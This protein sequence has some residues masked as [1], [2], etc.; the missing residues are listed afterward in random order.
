MLAG[1]TD[2][3]ASTQPAGAVR[4]SSGATQELARYSQQRI[5]WGTCRTGPA[6]KVGA[7]LDTAGA[8]CGTVTVPVDY[9]EPAGRTLTVAISRRKATDP[10]HRR[11]ILLINPGGPGAPGLEQVL[12]A[13]YLP[14]VAARYDLIGM[15]PRF[16]GRSTPLGCQWHTDT[17][18]RSAGPD[19]ASFEQ[20][21][22]LARELA[23]S[24]A[25]GNAGLLPHA[26]TLNT[27]RD[28]DLIRA[29]LGEEKLSYF[30]VS[31]GTYLGALY[32]QLFGAR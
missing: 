14:A 10:A 20:S 12:L 1:V 28:M 11:G 26:S 4:G 2:A 18:L 19:R 22:D 7:A 5:S 25:P 30:G 31:Y 27:A 6:D 29:V 21:A 24:C 13:P 32:L 8:Q 23:A 9:R 15:D 17:F 16:T 3:H